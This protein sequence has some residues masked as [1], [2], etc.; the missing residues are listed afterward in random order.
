MKSVAIGITSI[1]GTLARHRVAEN[2]GKSARLETMVSL[3]NTQY[4]PSAEITQ[5][6]D[7]T[8]LKK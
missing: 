7:P 6:V 8:V 3:E 4:A 5:A 1:I 2:N